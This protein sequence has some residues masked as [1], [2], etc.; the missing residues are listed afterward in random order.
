A[1]S[2]VLAFF[3]S[4]KTENNKFKIIVDNRISLHYL[5]SF[6]AASTIGMLPR[7]LSKITSSFMVLTSDH[8]KNNL[9]LSIK[10]E[11]K[12]LKAGRYWEF[13]EK[14]VDLI[15]EYKVGPV[16]TKGATVSCWICPTIP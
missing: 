6:K 5:P 14:A 16:W 1:L 2:V 10:F 9:G 13:S 3:L 15:C 7:V 4:D 11:A 12:G 8:Q